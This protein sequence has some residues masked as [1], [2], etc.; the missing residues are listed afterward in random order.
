[1]L[2]KSRNRVPDLLTPSAIWSSIEERDKFSAGKWCRRFSILDVGPPVFSTQCK[3]WGRSASADSR[4]FAQSPPSMVSKTPS[5]FMRVLTP[6]P[7]TSLAESQLPQEETSQDLHLFINAQFDKLCHLA[8]N[9]QDDS[10]LGNLIRQALEAEAQSEYSNLTWELEFI[11]DN[12]PGYNQQQVFQGDRSR[13]S[14]SGSFWNQDTYSDH[15]QHF[16]NPTSAPFQRQVPLPGDG[17]ASA[18]AALDGFYFAKRVFFSIQPCLC[19]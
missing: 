3:K 19:L 6:S 10:G 15:R 13:P 18:P 16:A 14:F 4:H 9:S 8:N 17:P 1:M 2:V 7:P 11:P 12:P 5:S